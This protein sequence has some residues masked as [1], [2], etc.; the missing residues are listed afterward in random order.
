[1]SNLLDRH[2]ELIDVQARSVIVR[3]HLTCVGFADDES[4]LVACVVALSRALQDLQ[5]AH[6]KL[7]AEGPAPVIV[8][9][10]EQA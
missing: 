10:S 5:E 8:V 9:L 7:L 6:A 2:P 1:M 4:V 3:A